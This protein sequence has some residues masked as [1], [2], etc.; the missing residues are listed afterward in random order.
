V[1]GEVIAWLAALRCASAGVKAMSRPSSG[2]MNL[3]R[4]INFG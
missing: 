3:G 4:R 1:R 2:R